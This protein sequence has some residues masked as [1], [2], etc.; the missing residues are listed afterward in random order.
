MKWEAQAQSFVY[1]GSHI[2]LISPDSIEVHDVQNG[3]L[4][5]VIEAIDIRL[6]YFNHS[7]G[8]ND[9]IIFGMKGK[10]DD[11]DDVRHKVFELA[12]TMELSSPLQSPIA[13]TVHYAY[14][15]ARVLGYVVLLFIPNRSVELCS[16]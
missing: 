15:G 4:L 10:K 11:N 2:L 1:R 6:L 3:R 8:S 13:E 14:G 9:P 16:V 12:E 7:V 5:Q